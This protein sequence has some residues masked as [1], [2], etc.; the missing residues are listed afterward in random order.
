LPAGS[1]ISYGLRH[2]FR[3]D[4]IV[5]TV[6]IGYADGVPRSLSSNGGEVLIGGRRMPIVGRVTMD[7]I[8]VD[9]GPVASANG[10]EGGR[11]IPR[12]GDEVVLLGTQSNES[13][14]PWDW[15]LALDTIAYEITCGI[16]KRV[17][18]IYSE[19]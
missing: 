13:I 12:V 7:Q 8:M 5:A 1:R 18:R 15:A 16:T 3:V 11:T 14:T 9:C 6:P 10:A 2:E 19:G 4:S 17:P